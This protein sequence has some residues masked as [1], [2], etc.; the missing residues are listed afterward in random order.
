MVHIMNYKIYIYVFCVLLCIYAMS[1]LNYEKFI[2]NNK[3][4]EARIFFLIVAIVIGYLLGNFII[5]FTNL[6]LLF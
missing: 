6:E 3:V 4:I 2:K 1:C 5:E